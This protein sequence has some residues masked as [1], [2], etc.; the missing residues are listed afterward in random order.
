MKLLKRLILSGYMGIPDVA[1]ERLTIDIADGITFL[2]GPNNAGKSIAHRFLHFL[3]PNL[4]GAQFPYVHLARGEFDRFDIWNAQERGEVHAEFVFDALN[5][6]PTR[7]NPDELTIR[8]VSTGSS[9]IRT[10]F[11]IGR[12]AD[13]WVVLASPWVK[14]A[15]CEGWLYEADFA[16]G[17]A[18]QKMLETDG[19][20]KEG[21]RNPQ[22]DLQFQNLIGSNFKGR[23]Y[24]FDAVRATD[25]KGQRGMSDGSGVLKDLWDWQRDGQRAIEW[26]RFKKRLISHLNS[27]FKGAAVPALHDLEM[28]SQNRNTSRGGSEAGMQLIFEHS[29]ELSIYLEDMGTGISQLVIILSALLKQEAFPA[30]FF[31]EEPETN[32]HPGLLRRFIEV[33]RTFKGVQFIITTHSN[34]LLDCISNVD[35]VYHFRQARDG[36]CRARKCELL[37]DQHAI[38]DSLGVSAGALLQANAVI[39]VEGPSDRLYLREWIATSSPEFREGSDYEFGFYGGKLLAHFTLVHDDEAAEQFIPLLN[40][41]RYSVVLMDRDL[42]P[43]EPDTKLRKTKTRILD[44][45]K[46]DERH[47]GAFVTVGREIEND[48]P[49]E[50]LLRGAAAVLE[51]PFDNL[52]DAAISGKEGYEE[53]ILAH[54]KLQGDTAKPFRR[55]LGNKVELARCALDQAKVAKIEMKPPAYVIGI[56]QLIER[57]GGLE[58]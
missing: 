13:Q 32:L 49:A 51:K 46:K 4:E 5:I 42:G 28:K 39:W 23:I 36:A 50:V 47:R 19:S 6:F 11:V 56:C 31:I 34:V 1:D 48:I 41:S 14:N 3:L 8:A 21:V 38:L 43:E 10:R 53:E 12:P 55:K 26:R 35:A 44:E 7:P 24:F 30:A 18:N 54:L 15:S 2:I 57:A 52:K 25:R 22:L 9:E 45:A 17:N 37:A 33:I 27:I 58:V 29:S 16:G 40:L 20:R